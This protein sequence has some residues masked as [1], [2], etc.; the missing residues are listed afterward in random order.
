MLKHL[1][2]A[3]IVSFLLLSV[4]TFVERV[5]FVHG[6]AFLPMSKKVVS[7]N[8]E[9]IVKEL[10]KECKQSHGENH[11]LEVII[12]TKDRHY[13]RCGSFWLFADDYE[14]IQKKDGD[15]ARADA[16]KH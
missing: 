10:A 13:A 6:K 4:F 1:F 9:E 7:G 2:T 8:E 16:N 12:E 3:L 5:M 11:T 15:S 14:L